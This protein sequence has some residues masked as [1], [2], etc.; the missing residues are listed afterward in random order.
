MQPLPAADLKNRAQPAPI[1]IAWAG[2]IALAVA[3]GIGRFAFTP[4]L[5]M[6]LHDGVIDLGHGSHLATANYL[7]YLVGALLCMVLPRIATGAVMIRIGLAATILLTA[8]M[9]L[10]WP[11]LWPVLRFA[12]G[13]ASALVF[14]FS[15]GWCLAHLAQHGRASLGATIFTGPGVGIA[16]SGLVATLLVS[17][18]LR[19]SIAWAIFAGLALVLSAFCW[20]VFRGPD[21]PAPVRATVTAQ[22]ASTR[23]S[24]SHAEMALF[25]L[26]YGIAGFGYIITATFLPVIARTTLPGSV[27]LDLFWPILGLGVVIGA[28]IAAR[29]PHRIDP[30]ILLIA[31]YLIQALGVVLC[32]ILPSLIGFILSSFLVGLPF[33]ALSFFAM[34]DVRR[35]RPE[36][37]ARFMGL[38]TAI[39]GIGQIAGP[40]LA[41]HLLAIS[42]SPAEG[43]ARALGTASATLVV[44]AGLY[45]IMRLCWPIDK[46][47]ALK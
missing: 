34:Q 17:L 5:P 1:Q 12:A 11:A 46:R 47:S 21:L 26:A 10:N 2:T 9:A 36:H 8:G 20:R 3:M 38:L 32:L 31:C 30:R 4:L 25:S 6:M 44:G 45:L 27:W 7:G 33:T 24:G 13:L 19:A 22:S 40:P 16:L 42:G 43:F 39:Y 18:Q 23:S 28:L 35:L 29:I 15:S 37:A 14:V 41:A